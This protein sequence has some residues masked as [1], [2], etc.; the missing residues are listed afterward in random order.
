MGSARTEKAAEVPP[1]QTVQAVKE[2]DFGVRDFTDRDITRLNEVADFLLER[3]RIKSRSPIRK[4][5]AP[6]QDFAP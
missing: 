1:E 4:V 2:L 6:N 5:F 3:N